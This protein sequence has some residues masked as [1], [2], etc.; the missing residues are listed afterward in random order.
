MVSHTLPPA[1]NGQASVLGRLFEG[2]SSAE[3]FYITS[4]ECRPLDFP[5][6][7]RGLVHRLPREPR[8]PCPRQLGP[9]CRIAEAI[10][11]VTQGYARAASIERI[12][13][14]QRAGAILATTGEVFELVACARAAER[15]GIPLY[16]HMLD[17]YSEKFSY[18]GGALGAVVTTYARQVEPSILAQA[19]R[20]IVTNELL[21]KILFDRD[22]LEASVIANPTD[23][24]PA[25][26]KASTA[27]PFPANG[28]SLTLVYTGA[29]YQANYGALRNVIG[30]LRRLSVPARLHIYCDEPVELLA[31][32]GIAG[33]V[34]ILPRVS[35]AEVARIQKES[36]VLVLP[37]AFDSPFPEVIRTSLP[38]KTADYLASGRPILVH[39]PADGFLPYY[40]REHDCG[41][42]VDRDD[43][44]AVLRSLES[45]MADPALRKRRIEN[46]LARARTDFVVDRV[47]KLFRKAV[48]RPALPAPAMIEVSTSQT[49]PTV[50]QTQPTVSVII[51]A[52]DRPQDLRA[53]VQSVL[54]DSDHL[55]EVIVVDDA[56][57]H[58]LRTALPRDP[59][60]RTVRL[61]IS[62]GPAA[63]RNH[64]LDL[65][66][67]KY[68]A[69]LDADDL[70]LPGKTAR[71]VAL[72]EANCDVALAHT[73]YRRIDEAGRVLETIASGTAD[74][75]I[76]PSLLRECPIATSTVM[77]LREA[78]GPLRFDTS[79]PIAEETVFWLRIGRESRIIGIDEAW[80]DVRM[81]GANVALNQEHLATEL[82]SILED[83]VAP[84]TIL[85]PLEKR[86]IIGRLRLELAETHRRRG[87]NLRALIER[88]RSF[89]VAPRVFTCARWILN[90]LRAKQPSGMPVRETSK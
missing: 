33:P 53:A 4:A 78:I 22:H 60:L 71:Q 1:G 5:P 67:G 54:A 38:G 6:A 2:W 85:S 79:R 86:R 75:W 34:E 59:R 70:F 11:L 40:F 42:V 57:P 82:R 43:E 76:Y 66:Q 50:S 77:L 14:H 80:V 31:R 81:H 45:L 25:D 88:T 62:G 72:L 7:L 18:L 29:V 48:D 30:A 3:Y 47:R 69:F 89:L 16:V 8:P 87:Q 52:Y 27:R 41:W 9:L 65:A 64:G 10:G 90:R 32:E 21:A 13:R 68:V 58:D 83:V 46:A 73:S 61:D 17:W 12:A 51:P 15:L 24:P 63:A 56:S 19:K 26:P 84:E 39:A 49:Q 23:T 28:E 37:L 44:D 36:D 35:P 20:V 55:L 74:G